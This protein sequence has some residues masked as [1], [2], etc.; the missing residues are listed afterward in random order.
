MKT[1]KSVAEKSPEPTLYERTQGPSDKRAKVGGDGVE[2]Y[3][4]DDDDLLAIPP[5]L[6]RK[7]ASQSS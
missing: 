1:V 6:R 2:R 5:F 4:D 7:P 3:R